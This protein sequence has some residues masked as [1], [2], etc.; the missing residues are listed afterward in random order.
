MPFVSDT[1]ENAHEEPVLGRA[2][3]SHQQT[4][5]SVM[6]NASAIRGRQQDFGS[7]V[8]NSKLGPTRPDMGRPMIASSRR[9]IASPSVVNRYLANRSCRRRSEGKQRGRKDA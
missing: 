9:E 4:L 8:L 3:P 1:D 5:R 2:K 7:C 6:P